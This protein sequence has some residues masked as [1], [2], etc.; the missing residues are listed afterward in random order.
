MSSR[1]RDNRM[2]LRERQEKKAPF[3]IRLT[4]S[5]IV[6]H[7]RDLQLRKA[8]FLMAVTDRSMI[9]SVVLAGARSPS[10]PY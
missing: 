9:A 2:D 4:V 8:Y 6:I 5:G 1:L 10:R 3:S 7:T